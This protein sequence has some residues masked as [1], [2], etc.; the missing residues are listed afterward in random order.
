MHI[1]HNVAVEQPLFHSALLLRQQHTEWIPS[2]SPSLQR[3]VSSITLESHQGSA[4]IMSA[5]NTNDYMA[6]GCHSS[7]TADLRCLLCLADAGGDLC[8]ALATDPQLSWYQK[9]HRI[10]LDIVRGL[11]FL[12]S[13]DVRLPA[14]YLSPYPLAPQPALSADVAIC[15]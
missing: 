12:H 9:G 4:A 3:R 11:Y 13:H 1:C 7:V 10:A 15:A 8:A 2:L 14:H 5:D 6:F